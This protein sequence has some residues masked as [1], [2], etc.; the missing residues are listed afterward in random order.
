MNVIPSVL[1]KGLKMGFP[2]GS[3]ALASEIS[4]IPWFA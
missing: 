2:K 4:S 1:E 3:L